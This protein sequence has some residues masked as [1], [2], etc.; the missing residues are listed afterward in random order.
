LYV[1][2]SLASVLVEK[3]DKIEYEKGKMSG[4]IKLDVRG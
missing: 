4:L 2:T 3:I 1:V